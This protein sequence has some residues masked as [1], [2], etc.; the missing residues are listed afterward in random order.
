LCFT[1]GSSAFMVV[2]EPGWEA[3]G[4]IIGWEG[5]S[6]LGSSGNWGQCAFQ[7]FPQQMGQG[8]G[9]SFLWRHSLLKWLDC[10]H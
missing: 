5:G 4:P 3:Q 10:P 8:P 9:G 2:T 1:R 6:G 7:C